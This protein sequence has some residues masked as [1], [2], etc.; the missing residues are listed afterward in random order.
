MKTLI[1]YFTRTGYTK[2]IVDK[3]Q[4]ELSADVEKIT[5]EG[6]RHGPLGWLKSGRQG[7]S[8][9]D[10]EIRPLEADPS[11]YELVVMASPVWSGNVSAPMRSFMKKYRDSLPETAVFLTHDSPDVTQAFADIDELLGKEPLARGDVNRQVIQADEKHEAVQ[12][13]LEKLSRA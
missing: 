6:S 10:V 4:T 8:K 5:E 3:L 9:A 1:V 11:S 7:S 2:K 13:F 12:E